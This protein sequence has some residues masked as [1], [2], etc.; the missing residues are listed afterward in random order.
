M[1]FSK[2]RTIQ[3]R[4]NKFITTCKV[5]P[6]TGDA[7]QGPKR[8][9]FHPT[10]RVAESMGDVMRCQWS[11]N[12]MSE[13]R[14]LHPAGSLDRTVSQYSTQEEQICRRRSHSAFA[15]EVPVRAASLLAP[16]LPCRT[17]SS[18]PSKQ[19]FATSWPPPSSSIL[20]GGINTFPLRRTGIPMRAECKT[21]QRSTLLST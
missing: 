17:P 6:S 11:R 15:R 19:H 3:S 16:R 10:N 4:R 8:E 5:V 1:T 9:E 12:L 21:A 18:S 13:N 2:T 14:L 20:S 7:Q